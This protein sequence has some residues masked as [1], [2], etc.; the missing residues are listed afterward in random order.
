MIKQPVNLQE[1]LRKRALKKSDS[2]AQLEYPKTPKIEKKIKRITQANQNTPDTTTPKV[3]KSTK[4]VPKPTD[5]TNTPQSGNGFSKE[6]EYFMF[7]E[8]IATPSML[9]SP[10][11][12]QE[13]AGRL[14]V[15][16][17]TLSDWKKRKGFWDK[18]EKKIAYANRERH[19]DVMH[20]FYMNLL[21]KGQGKDVL[22]WLQYVFGFNPKVM[23][24]DE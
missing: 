22:V 19:A 8:W 7:I 12:Q 1:F 4:S 10:K 23:F 5:P 16:E 9:R 3:Q 18:V 21:R 6:A 11:T 2:I 24:A 17:T 20:S 14:K 13:L 15:D